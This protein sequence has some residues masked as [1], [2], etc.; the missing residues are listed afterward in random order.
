MSNNPA[1][2]L[3]AD[4]TGITLVDLDHLRGEQPLSALTPT[5]V[6]KALGMA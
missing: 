3:L 1:V 4:L 5:A 6:L 2:T